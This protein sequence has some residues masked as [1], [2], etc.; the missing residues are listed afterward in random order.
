M[1]MLILQDTNTV[2]DCL[3]SESLLA[4][5]FNWIN[6]SNSTFTGLVQS[7]FIICRHV[8]MNFCS[9]D[10]WRSICWLFLQSTFPIYSS[11]LYI[12]PSISS[13]PSR[14]RY[15]STSTSST[16]SHRPARKD[17]SKES[18]QGSTQE[19]E[20]KERICQSR[21]YCA[22][23]WNHYITSTNLKSHAAKQDCYMHPN[24]SHLC[25]LSYWSKKYRQHHD[26]EVIRISASGTRYSGQ[27]V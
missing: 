12:Y 24:I 20:S 18:H 5:V 2:S 16:K 3:K 14:H 27:R 22:S 23:Y 19:T 7:D 26:Q 9:V 17:A 1:R 6:S 21:T 25:C 10:E 8:C 4:T 11:N 15:S 13:I